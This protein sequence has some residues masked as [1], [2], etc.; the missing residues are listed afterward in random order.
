MYKT[1]KSRKKYI[2][3]II[4]NVLSPVAKTIYIVHVQELTDI[5][6]TT[7]FSENSMS[8]PFIVKKS[9]KYLHTPEALLYFYIHTKINDIINN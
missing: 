4:L 3:L 6:L 1:S 5:I 8:E 7:C 9:N 2:L